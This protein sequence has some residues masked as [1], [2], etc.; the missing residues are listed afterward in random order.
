MHQWPL[1]PGTGAAAERGAGSGTGLT[2][3]IPLS[4]G[5]TGDVALAAFDLAID[6][7]VEAFAPT[8][9]VVSTGFDA[10]RDDPIGGLGWSSG[11][12][13]ALTGRVLAYAPPGRR[14]VFL[15]GCYDLPALAASVGA[16]VTALAGRSYQPE[17]PTSGGPG[18]DSVRAVS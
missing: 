7:A 4:P 2:R 17:P 10:H 5:A 14:L 12:Y 9:L 3:N 16:C 11:D 13:S 1:Y 6:P 15:E 18:M 8:W